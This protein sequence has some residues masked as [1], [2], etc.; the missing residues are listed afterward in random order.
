MSLTRVSSVDGFERDRQG[1][2]VS[3]H[4][5]MSFSPVGDWSPPHDRKAS[6]ASAAL[7]VEEVSKSKRIGMKAYQL[8][9]ITFLTDNSSSHRS[10]HILPFRRRRGLWLCGHQTRPDRRRCVQG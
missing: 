6:V 7:A 2:N 9:F 10:N 1:S 5:R 8:Y 3:Q 4:R